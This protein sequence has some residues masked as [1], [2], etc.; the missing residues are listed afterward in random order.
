MNLNN[1]NTSNLYDATKG[2]FEQLGIQLNSTT[3]Q[4][5][6]ASDVL[7][8]FYKD[9]EPFTS[10]RQVYFA[11]LIDN[12]IFQNSMY[13]GYTLD[14][15]KEYANHTY[16]GLM[17]FAVKFNR[18]PTRT[19]IS[20]LTRAFN[21]TSQQMPVGLLLSYEIEKKTAISLA[22]SERFLY[23]QAWREGE[24]IGKVII[25][26]DILV[27][28]TH[29]G[30]L[31]ILQ[32]LVKSVRITTYNELHTRWLKVLD[33]NILN[34]KFFQELSNWY[35]WAMGNV[36]FPD[37]REKNKEMRNAT[38]LIRL[39]TRIV[40]IWFI[41]EKGL[42]PERLFDAKL[43]SN[44]LKSFNK[45]KQSHNY[46]NAILQN[47]FFGTLN[48]KMTE[49]KFAKDVNG[50]INKNEYGVKNVYR[51][52]NLFT[53]SENEVQNLFKEVPFLNGGLFDCL[54]KNEDKKVEYVDGFSRN[55]KKQAIVPDY[56]FFGNEQDVDLNSIYDTKGKNYKTKG[57]INLLNSYKFTI[58]E[59]T[60]IEED[61]ALDPELLGKVF[62]NLLASYN[63]ET[64]TTARKQ[65]GSFYT[66]REIVNYMVDE[67]LIAYLKNYLSGSNTSELENKLRQLLDYNS[68]N[69]FDERDTAAIIE[70]I[71]SCKIL[72]PACGSGAFPMGI[73]HKMVQ[74]LQTLDYDNKHWREIQK[75]K[76]IAETEQAYDIGDKTDREHKLSEINDVFE[77]NASDYGRKLYLIE[78]CIFGVDIQPIAVQIAKLR[79]FISLIIDQKTDPNKENFGV[80][81][82]PNLETKFVAANTLIGLKKEKHLFRTSEIEKKENEIKMVN[83]NYFTAN[84]R[85][86]KVKLQQKSKILRHELSILL[87][88]TGFPK[89]E[90]EKIAKLDLFDQNSFEEWFDPEWM[91][92]LTKEN[93]QLN[94]VETGYFDIVIGN[95]PFVQLQKN[96]GELSKLYGPTKKDKKTIPS[97]Y[98]TFDSMGD[99]YSLF[100]ER[101]YNLLKAQGKLCFI[102]SN[103]WMRAGYGE[104][105]RKFFAENTNPEQLI[106]FAGIKV[107]ESATVDTNILLFSKDKNR[108]QTQACI[109]KKEGIKD[110]SVFIR[111]SS[112]V[113]S[114]GSDSWVVLS[115][116]EQ[117]IKAKIEA[118]GTPLKDW[119][120]RINYGIKTG[121]NDTFII[122]GKKR[123]ELIEQDSKSEEIIR[124]ILRGRD[125]K[126]YGYD[127]ADLWLINTHNGIKEKGVKPI[128]IND[129]P[130][131]KNHLDKYYPELEKRADKG[132]TPYNL[133]NCAY[134][135]DFY[136]Q[137][138]V[139]KI[140][141]SNINFLIDNDGYFYNNAANI[142]TSNTIE[143]ESLI[144]FLNSKLFEWYF[145]R[146]IFIEVEGGGI[147]MFNTVMEYIPIP[148]L[149]K[150]EQTPFVNLVKAI[151]EKQTKGI[152]T[153]T[154]EKELELLI[155]NF[156]SL[157]KE[158][159][160]IIGVIEIQ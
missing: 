118:V 21:R 148:L 90:A 36:E 119:D 139:W 26:R 110:L 77:N 149:N 87:E 6:T 104:N 28:N 20:E 132:D 141:G 49:R 86:Q 30:H 103:K 136:K 24:K 157:S 131:I 146:M 140:I 98:K 91:F 54:D 137:K 96:G 59:N 129:Y 1:F 39:I 52:A 114:F 102:T 11:G 93:T 47:L 66:P 14:E 57:L 108:Q 145:K 95:P 74:I 106:D 153:K 32:D 5:F 121:F 62:E 117:R 79:F 40:F 60:P 72:D 10:I 112:S 55:P 61:V 152:S 22:L 48:Q 156:F 81:S 46:Y 127:F 58:T 17:L 113:C 159:R 135:E 69:P 42:V 120:I 23:K 65:T 73:L 64:K 19:D 101:G 151:I 15:A 126:R 8:D 107:F 76:A 84:N 154:T 3:T 38:N 130:A 63:P 85:T 75:R 100:Y 35:F 56:L 44:L 124:P 122:S 83:H 88:D 155:C 51:Y 13:S 82:L 4:A 18:Y 37:D 142:L 134:M 115:P 133:R 12:S 144:A 128:D 7:K 158:E 33:V 45:D 150:K 25:L 80:R 31:Y 94:Q 89:D 2:L 111:Q 116:I 143:L 68:E 123:K 125:I 99:L 27:E 92:G 41:K 9:R 53:L 105:T 16:E 97:P 147:Q 160:E 78:N 50:L 43:M 138:I 71:N 67:S 109:V 34:K 70:A 29:A